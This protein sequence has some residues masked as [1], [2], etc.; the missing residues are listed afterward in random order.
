VPHPY[1][2]SC[3]AGLR[4]ADPHP[5]GLRQLA[6]AEAAAAAHGIGGAGPFSAAQAGPSGEALARARS[7]DTHDALARN[8][9]SRRS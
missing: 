3:I 6:E 2:R 7:A 1:G 8:V 5:T 4:Q 9:R